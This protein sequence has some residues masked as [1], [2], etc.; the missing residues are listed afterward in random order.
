MRSGICVRAEPSVP[1]LNDPASID[2]ALRA[3]HDRHDG[4]ALARLY[5][6]AAALKRQCGDMEAALF[7]TV[8]AYIHALEQGLPGAERLRAVLVAAGREA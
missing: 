1:D 8:Q 3:A 4:V 6:D 5:E 7:L 2:A